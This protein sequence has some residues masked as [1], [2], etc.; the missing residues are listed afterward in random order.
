M[1][2]LTIIKAGGQVLD[3]STTLRAFVQDFAALQGPKILVHG[4]GKIASAIGQKL[5]IEPQYVDGRRITDAAT[6]E[7][8]TMVYGGLINRQL[9]ALLQEAS[10]NAIGL[11]GADGALL[12]A[13]KRPAGR[14]DYGFVG[15][16]SS[17]RVNVQLLQQLLQAGLAPVL[18]P[19]TYDG[20]GGLLNTNADTIAQET[21]RAMSRFFQVQL[22]YCFGMKGVLADV[23]DE[24][25]VIPRIN[26]ESFEQLKNDHIISE[27]MI[28]KL[29][30]ALLA[31]KS[32]VT[33][34][35][36]GKAQDLGLLIAGSSGTHITA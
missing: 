32:G 21:A 27:G 11:T 18:A 3:D 25:S 14:V 8:V 20:A 7:L 5:G 23:A 17:D 34:V 10:C 6:L 9:V 12:P 29:E 35:S 15:D 22:V 4:G 2:T 26:S 13:Q 16:V 31:V 33:R 24:G 1:Q 30:N 19:L 36:I 28:P